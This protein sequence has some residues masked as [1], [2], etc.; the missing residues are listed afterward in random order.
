MR[1]WLIADILVD[2]IEYFDISIEYMLLDI[3]V[4]FC[5]KFLHQIFIFIKKSKKSLSQKKLGLKSRPPPDY[6]F[7]LLFTM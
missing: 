1:I 6:I 7:D 5:I 2:F 3:V 4:P